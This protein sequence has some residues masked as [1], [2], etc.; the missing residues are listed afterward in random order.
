VTALAPCR[1]SSLYNI[2]VSNKTLSPL[3]YRVK[4]RVNGK[5]VKC[6]AMIDC[7][8]TNNLINPRLVKAW[9]TNTPPRAEPIH[10]TIADGREIASG[11]VTEDVI[12]EIKVLQNKKPVSLGVANIGRHD[13]ILG[14][15]WL[16]Q[17]D[18][19]I[20]FKRCVMWWPRAEVAAYVSKSAEIE[21]AHKKVVVPVKELVPPEYHKYLNVFSEE[22]A[23]KLA[24]HREY[25]LTID[26]KPDAKMHSGPIYPTNKVEGDTI[27]EYIDS[28][29]KKGFIQHSKAPHRYP[30]IF[31]K[32]KDRLL[33][34]CI[35]YRHLNEVTIRNDYCIPLQSMLTNQVKG[36]KHFTALDLQNSYHLLHIAKG[37]EWKTAF[38]TRYGQFEYKVMPFGLTN[39]PAAFQH[40]MNDLFKDLLDKG[41]VVYI[42]DI[43]IYSKTLEEH[44][45]LVKEVLKRLQENCCRCGLTDPNMDRR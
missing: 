22:E 42:D 21:S 5:A 3:F 36:A 19:M 7:G 6:K 20:S 32:K 9:W 8:T 35:D 44:Q 39:A 2:S 23:S 34:M 30:V 37:H 16:A 38:H 24:P 15:L 10:L 43:L 41:I 28:M 26:L 14:M 13:I 25:D 12:G 31:M 27:K 11:C 40:L 18:P 1:F 33:C 4:L 17:A 45:V 29:M